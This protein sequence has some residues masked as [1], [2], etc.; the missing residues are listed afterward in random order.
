MRCLPY[1]SIPSITA[2]RVRS[3]LS[4]MRRQSPLGSSAKE[5][6][7]LWV[8]AARQRVRLKPQARRTGRMRAIRRHRTQPDKPQRLCSPRETCGEPSGAQPWPRWMRPTKRAASIRRMKRLLMHRTLPRVQHRLVRPKLPRRVGHRVPP[9]LRK[10]Q[11]VLTG[12]LRQ[13]VERSVSA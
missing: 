5:T 12:Q 2:R 10:Q 13:Q 1:A 8:L 4:M 7:A 11:S 6:A 3:A 9:M